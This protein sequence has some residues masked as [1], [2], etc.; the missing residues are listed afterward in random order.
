ML[1]GY[2]WG[3]GAVIF[4]SGGGLEE[5]GRGGLHVVRAMAGR[6][7]AASLNGTRGLLSLIHI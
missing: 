3:M 7:G 2:R 6:A 5:A 1:R 4:L